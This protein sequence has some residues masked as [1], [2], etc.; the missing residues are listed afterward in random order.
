MIGSV[1]GA[2]LLPLG[3]LGY[4]AGLLPLQ[5]AFF[6]FLGGGFVLGALALLGGIA[7]LIVAIRS[8]RNADRPLLYIGLLLGGVVV[9][10][11]LAQVGRARSVPPIHDISTD[12]GDPPQFDQVVGLRG[13]KSNPLDYDAAKLGP[14]TQAAFPRVKSITTERAAR[15]SFDRSLDV[16]KGMHVE[17]VN[18]DR[19]AGRIEAVAT[20]FWFGFKDDVVV[21]VRESG[22]GAIVDLRSVSRVGVSDLGVNAKRIEEFIDR[23]NEA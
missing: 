12:V 11:M 23:F 3:A 17:I 21:R 2:V 16:L 7:A 10:L 4:R 15:E 18:A 13:D 6:V 20:S 8:G 19:D 1:I 9:V 14:A 5:A 22:S